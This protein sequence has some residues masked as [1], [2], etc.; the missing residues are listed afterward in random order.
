MNKDNKI[1]AETFLFG[2]AQRTFPR[3]AR[4]QIHFRWGRIL[5]AMLG[6][7]LAGWMSVAG[8]LY[9]WFK[10]KHEYEDVTYAKMV[11]LPFRIDAHRRELGDY[12]IQTAKAFIQQKKYREA[13]DY[14]RAG[15]ARSYGNLEGRRML[16]EFYDF[17]HHLHDEAARTLV[18]GVEHGGVEDP[19]YMSSVYR[20]LLRH[21]YDDRIIELG[22]QLL[23]EEIQQDKVSRLTALATATAYFNL[24]KHD[25][26]LRHIDQY[27]LLEVPEGNI[28]VAQIYWSRGQREK[29]FN[30][31][32]QTSEKFP[33]AAQVHT[34]ISDFHL[35]AGNLHAARRSAVL[36]QVTNPHSQD[37]I[38]KVLE[39]ECKLDMV[40]RANNSFQ[41][42]LN[43]FPSDRA[44]LLKTA[45]LVARLGRLD[46][47]LE[48][49]AR[50]I[51]AGID[52]A[53]FPLSVLSACILSGEHET[54]LEQGKALLASSGEWKVSYHRSMLLCLI[55][56]AAFGKGDLELGRL[57]LK[58]FLQS[59][60]PPADEIHHL[61]HHFETLGLPEQERQV[62]EFGRDKHPEYRPILEELVR[63][64]LARQ[65]HSSFP[66][67]LRS[68][69]E[70][71]RK[72]AHL[73]LECQAAMSSDQFLFLPERKELTESLDNMLYKVEQA[74]G[75]PSIEPTDS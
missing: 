29:A 47:A 41:D 21:E 63:R 20:F 36:A 45:S 8:A 9:F 55:S 10:I 66:E 52:D 67:D 1:H 17:G 4:P 50:S 59:K 70:V 2:F 27:D 53:R 40:D 61:A 54:A 12:H 11:A 73:L 75:L 60:E 3:G 62:L 39:L 48:V 5:L 57:H 74:G 51:K 24:F 71:R 14:L 19:Q 68:M 15:V 33:D 46:Y 34:R 28:L 65:D 22:E 31:L 58:D 38:L 72:N 37:V 69:L 7:V 42:V 23:K 18:K 6:V 49:E 64:G 13:F 25:N 32:A 43:N 16:A 44:T 35:E 30:L 56:A 26:A